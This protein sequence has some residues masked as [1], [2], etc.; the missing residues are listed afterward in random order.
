MVES[1]PSSD[2]VKNRISLV[3]TGQH[4]Q[5]IYLFQYKNDT[6]EV[7]FTSLDDQR[8]WI[9]K[10][11]NEIYEFS[12]KEEYLRQNNYDDVFQAIDYLYLHGQLPSQNL[13]RR[14]QPIYFLPPPPSVTPAE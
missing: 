4:D 10:N 13:F 2:T 9:C 11:V 8:L 1:L 7:F 6:Y 14:D 12:T 3:I 5:R